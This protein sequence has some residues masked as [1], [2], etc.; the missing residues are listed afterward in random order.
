MNHGAIAKERHRLQT[1]RKRELQEVR[2]LLAQAEADHQLRLQALQAQCA[3]LGHKPRSQRLT[4][5]IV[6]WWC[7]VCGDEEARLGQRLQGPADR[8]GR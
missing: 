4:S 8:A 3:A 1:A 6:R 2:V 7:L 5:G